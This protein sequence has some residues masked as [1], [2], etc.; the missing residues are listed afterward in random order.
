MNAERD[1]NALRWLQSRTGL[2]LSVFLGIVGFLLVTK[3]TAHFFGILPYA[4][5]YPLLHPFMRGRHG[6]RG[7]HARHTGDAEGKSSPVPGDKS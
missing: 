7:A 5:L 4:L 6:A 2:A 3:H 1:F